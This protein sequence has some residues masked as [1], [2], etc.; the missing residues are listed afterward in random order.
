MNTQPT[1]KECIYSYWDT[2]DEDTKRAIFHEFKIKHKG[3]YT[4]KDLLNFL[5]K[6]LERPSEPQANA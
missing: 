3:C 5:E 6:K 2:I 4:E 1:R